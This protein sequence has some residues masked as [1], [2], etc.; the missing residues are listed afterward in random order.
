MSGMGLKAGLALLA[1]STAINAAP[2]TAEGRTLAPA[3]EWQVERSDESCRLRRDTA[4]AFSL[5]AYGPDGYSLAVLNG[6]S[7]PRNSGR[8]RVR[9]VAFGVEGAPEEV[10]VVDNSSGGEGM[11]SF[12][13]LGANPALSYFRGWEVLGGFETSQPAVPQ[14]SDMSV[15][16]IGGGEMEPI[17]LL[18]GDMAEPMADLDDCKAALT[19]SWGYDEDMLG[20]VAE[21]PVLENRANIINKMKMPEAAV[22]N[23]VTMIA[24]MRVAVDENGAASDCT[25]Q[26]PSLS[27][28]A[29]RGLCGPL[30]Q[31]QPFAPARNA[32]GQAVPGLFRMQYTYFIFN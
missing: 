3:G 29:Q 28:R 19:E 26:Y 13:L 18:L 32:L 27:T 21:P 8:A 6:A 12:H 15:L 5:Y 22:M 9:E 23:H 1:V 2:A 24:Q 11:V 16:R 10:I 31:G 20:Q 14:P 4:V 7:L 25:V 30:L 17:T